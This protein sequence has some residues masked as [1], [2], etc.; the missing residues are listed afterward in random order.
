MTAQQGEALDFLE[1]VAERPELQVR[2]YQQRGD[3]V[4]MNNWTTLHRRTSFED[5]EEPELRRHLI[6]AWLSVP[7]SRPIDPLFK[8]NFGATEAG[9]IRGG[10]RASST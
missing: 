7:N 9:A 3:I 10:M 2:F 4:L 1:S 5:H 8:E 6:R